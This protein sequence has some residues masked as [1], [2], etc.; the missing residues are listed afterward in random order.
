[1]IQR[2][3]ASQKAR[4]PG[5]ARRDQSAASAL[6]P[7]GVMAG[8]VRRPGRPAGRAWARCCASSR[9]RAAA[10][11]RAA[12]AAGSRRRRGAR[13]RAA[14]RAEIALLPRAPARGP[15]RRVARGAARALRGGDAAR[16]R[17]P[18]AAA[19]RS[20]CSPTALLDALAFTR[21]PRRRAGAARAARRRRRPRRRLELGR[22]AARAARRDRARGALDGAVASAEVGAAK[23]D[24]AIFARALALAGVRAEEAWHVGDSVDADVEGA[25]AAGLRPVLWRATAPR[26]RPP[27]VPVLREPGRRCP[28]LVAAGDP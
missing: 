2:L 26:G 1:M 25:L 27:G 3:F 22:L 15:R 12:R 10:A 7:C 23:P 16:A 4:P 21:L 14:I 6:A 11:R 28:A 9:S 24:P 8:E 20:A 19:S 18:P 17:P 5:R 13:P